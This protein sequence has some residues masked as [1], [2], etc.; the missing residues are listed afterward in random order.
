ML[1][2]GGSIQR[3]I[4]SCPFLMKLK[5][6][7]RQSR[8]RSQIWQSR[9]LPPRLHSLLLNLPPQLPFC[10]SA[11]RLWHEGDYRQ[12]T[13]LL[14]NFYPFLS[15]DRMQEKEILTQSKR[16]FSGYRYEVRYTLSKDGAFYFNYFKE[17][18]KT[19]LPGWKSLVAESMKEELPVPAFSSALNYFY[20]L[21]SADLP[22]NMVQ[23]QRDYFGA[24]T[25]ERKDELRGQFFHE[26]WTGHGGDTKS[27]TY[28]V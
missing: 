5:Q 15:R 6:K 21:T 12:G 9:C 8:T 24:H 25:F 16:L 28:N 7:S 14:A 11:C 4:P 2:I 19:L 13:A 22:A 27:G 23:A 20:S 17:E 3:R 26:N 1:K 10:R 18:M